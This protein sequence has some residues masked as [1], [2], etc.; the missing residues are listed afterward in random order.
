ML[1]KEGPET[2]ATSVRSCDESVPYLP[3]YSGS[4]CVGGLIAKWRLDENLS[5][6]LTLNDPGGGTRPKGLYSRSFKRRTC[7]A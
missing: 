6:N 7:Q 4:P 1:E 2:P 3:G 5:L